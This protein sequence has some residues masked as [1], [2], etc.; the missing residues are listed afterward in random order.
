[1]IASAATG[2]L[3]FN[4]PP[5]APQAVC[6]KARMYGMSNYARKGISSCGEQRSNHLGFKD[7][8][9]LAPYTD[10]Q[11]LTMLH[12]KISVCK[13]SV[14]AFLASL[15]ATHVELYRTSVKYEYS[16]LLKFL[17]EVNCTFARCATN[18]KMCVPRRQKSGAQRVQCRCHKLHT[19]CL[20]T[21]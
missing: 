1:M 18:P 21:R 2:S 10:V 16:S 3:T 14:I 7:Q 12:A 17:D 9:Y 8:E 5:R 6:D 11:L 19:I 4:P 20:S 13:C 15:S